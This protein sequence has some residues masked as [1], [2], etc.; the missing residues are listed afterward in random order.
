[1]EFV[2]FDSTLH[3]FTEEWYAKYNGKMFKEAFRSEIET[4][5][6]QSAL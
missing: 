4:D 3:G 6:V 1:M 2:V 5:Y